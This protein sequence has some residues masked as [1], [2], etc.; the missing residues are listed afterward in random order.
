MV[1]HDTMSEVGTRNKCPG[2]WCLTGPEDIVV[3]G[4]V[5]LGNWG[6]GM[7]LVAWP[8]SLG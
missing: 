7:A 4:S 3:V 1:N 5:S 2:V 6:S 8:V